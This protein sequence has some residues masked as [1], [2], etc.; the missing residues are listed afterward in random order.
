MLALFCGLLFGAVPVQ[1][2][3]A[4]SARAGVA[5][6]PDTAHRPANALAR[7]LGAV[8]PRPPISPKR[9]FFESVLVPGWGQASLHRSTA[10][11]IFMTVEAVSVAML[12]QSKKELAN[13]RQVASDSV[14]DHYQAPAQAG[15][16]PIPVHA[17]NDL[18][19]RI[20]PRRQAVEDWAALLIFN[21][22][23]SGADAFVA[24]HLWNVPVSV[25]S[26]SLDRRLVVGA[27]ITW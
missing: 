10:G 1:A 2:Q 8:A 24:A 20:N 3:R 26:G 14:V 5:P 4:D 13:A 15:G 17:P 16:A 7:P 19:G 11:A 9:A 12:M 23:L 22:L 21:H 18:R 25:T 27:H 6:P